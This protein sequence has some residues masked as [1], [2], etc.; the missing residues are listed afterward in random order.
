MKISFDEAIRL[1]PHTPEFKP[2]DILIISDG[3]EGVLIRESRFG[4]TVDVNGVEK[5]FMINSPRSFTTV[6]KKYK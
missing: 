3:T 5:F 4:Y 1:D 2:G 6:R